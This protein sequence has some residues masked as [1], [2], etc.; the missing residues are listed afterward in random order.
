M[1]TAQR[2]FP[3]AFLVRWIIQAAIAGG[4]AAAVVQTFKALLFIAV[5][6][7]RL[8]AI[9]PLIVSAAAAVVVGLLIYRIAPE[10]AGEGIPAYLDALRREDRPMPI[11]ATIFK[12]P[13]ALITL[14]SYGSGG[15][16]GPIGRVVSGL[17]QW[18]TGLLARVMP[19]LFEDRREH[20]TSYHAPT[21]AAISGMAAGV[22]ALFHSPIAGAVFAVEVIQRDQLRYH[23]I[24]PAVLAS[25]AAVFFARIAGWSPV[26][27]GSLPPFEASGRVLALVV[28][29]GVLTGGLGILYT[30]LYQWMAALFGRNRREG[31]I[32]RLLIGMTLSTAIGI[33]INPEL[34]GTALRLVERLV[35]GELFFVEGLMARVAL[36]VALLLLLFA[37]ILTNC[38]TVASGMS[39]G[40]TGP[41]LI[42]GMLAGAL[43]AVLVGTAPGSATYSIL[44][45]AGLAGMLASTMNT[46]LAAAILAI[47]LFDASYGIPAGLAAMIGFQTARYNTIYE[48][49]LEQR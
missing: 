25:S 47:E 6:S 32:V 39:A 14:A 43:V 12:Y 4:L 48:A 9:H 22:A 37:K 49:A 28:L 5:S 35:N 40:F 30:K 11:G 33:A 19:R 3:A 13:A 18:L 41:A 26:Y 29:V 36:P 8:T 45:V 34:L 20:E 44:I 21:T 27:S 17:S 7:E 31:Q 38:L 23:Q 16:V 2:S 1:N 24:F 15:A 46:P 10:A 42:V